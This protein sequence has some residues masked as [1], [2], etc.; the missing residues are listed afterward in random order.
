MNLLKNPVTLVTLV[1]AFVVLA[2]IVALLVLFGHDPSQYISS[3]GSL[4]VVVAGILTLG[5]QQQKTNADV[6]QVKSQTNGTLSAKDATIEQQRQQIT[7]LTA[8]LVAQHA[9]PDQVSAAQA[10]QNAQAVTATVPTIPSPTTAAAVPDLTPIP[11]LPTIP[12]A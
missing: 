3:L 1:A 11:L 2:G 6:A 8:S 12:S 4:G 5:A 7:A 9:A 10:V